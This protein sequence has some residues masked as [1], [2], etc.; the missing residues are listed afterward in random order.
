LARI[1]L[2]GALYYF[3]LKRFSSLD[4]AKARHYY[5]NLWALYK[6]SL[7]TSNIEP[8]QADP[9]N[10]ALARFCPEP[11]IQA[12]TKDF[13]LELL[14]EAALR[15]AEAAKTT[16]ND[17]DEK[18][19]LVELNK[20][21]ALKPSPA[22]EAKFALLAIL[23]LD[24]FRPN[25]WAE[26][27]LAQLLA[28]AS[29]NLD[30]LKAQG[31][32]AMMA[33]YGEDPKL[34]RPE[35][36]LKE[37]GTLKP[38]P[39]VLE[40][41]LQALAWLTSQ[42]LARGHFK[43]AFAL[44]EESLALAATLAQTPPVLAIMA[45]LLLT[46]LS[47]ALR[48]DRSRLAFYTW[49]KLLNLPASPQAN[50]QKARAALTLITQAAQ[51]RDPDLAVSLFH[52]LS[53]VGDTGA[54][55][56]QLT[57]ALSAL[58]RSLAKEG[59]HD[60]MEL[61]LKALDALDDALDEALDNKE[62]SNLDNAQDKAS[63]N[64]NS[65][66]Y[67]EP[68]NL[69]LKIA[70]PPTSSDHLAAI[71]ADLRVELINY[72]L[73]RGKSEA[74]EA[75][76]AKISPGLVTAR[77]RLELVFIRRYALEGQL[78]PAQKRLTE[79]LSL[80]GSDPE[81]RRSQADGLVAIGAL[82]GSLGDLT[83]AQATFLTLEAR[84]ETQRLTGEN[85]DNA[86]PFGQ[87]LFSLWESLGLLNLALALVREEGAL[88]RELFN[89]I[90]AKGEVWRLAEE[91]LLGSS[92]KAT[93]IMGSHLVALG[94]IERALNLTERLPLPH[95]KTRAR[96]HLNLLVIKKLIHLKRVPQ[97]EPLI[98]ELIDWALGSPLNPNSEPNLEFLDLLGAGLFALTVAY[99]RAG[100]FFPKFQLDR[101]ARPTRHKPDDTARTLGHG[102][103]NHALYWLEKLLALPTLGSIPLWRGKAAHQM[104]VALLAGAQT[105]PA[106]RIFRLTPWPKPTES[107]EILKTR[108][109][110]AFALIAALK[111][112]EPL[113]ACALFDELSEYFLGFVE[114]YYLKDLGELALALQEANCQ[115]E[116][117]RVRS[118]FLSL[119][120]ELAKDYWRNLAGE[121]EAGFDKPI[122]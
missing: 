85:A 101:P 42:R 18:G 28:I 79:L 47:A 57:H 68:K 121:L 115:A 91:A 69:E 24:S 87:E 43:K 90:L 55:A 119:K 2:Y 21:W 88:G 64:K 105:S 23:A 49:E 104:I 41:K 73:A 26:D 46:T 35:E 56:G 19:W 110:S 31:L 102:P 36:L 114:L 53:R 118:A 32:L 107:Y 48:A 70:N 78:E 11:L 72:Y 81:L 67:N 40:L 58:L 100:R 20:I 106:L 103:T 96:A 6:E 94:E 116:L 113:V 5:Q 71:K 98:R 86:S 59:R 17:Q 44:I 38:T 84:L 29:P 1:R 8:N 39:G 120:S 92:L 65:R 4:L 13:M 89:A 93:L 15:L 77:A 10:Q 52:S 45:N 112:C 108:L 97:A 117:A 16:S 83:L 7:K 9:I 62:E 66:D 50:A 27:F 54:F 3:F 109:N 63:L 33:F 99:A 111:N 25:R 80:K 14:G 122:R 95:L 12:K 51:N 34:S 22:K 30:P 74:A 60:Q 37:W 61:Y 76:A 75:L 82:A